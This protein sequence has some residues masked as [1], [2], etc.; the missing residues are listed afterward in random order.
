MADADEEVRAAEQ[1]ARGRSPGGEGDLLTVPEGVL[2]DLGA[3]AKAVAADLA[4][5][6]VA[7]RTGSGVLVELGGDI[8][9]RGAH[10]AGGWQILVDD[11]PGGRWAIQ[12]EGWGHMPVCEVSAILE[13]AEAIVLMDNGP[14]DA[15]D[16]RVALRQGRPVVIAEASSSVRSITPL[17][18]DLRQASWRCRRD[19]RRSRS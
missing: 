8:A 16:R 7:S 14:G 19:R 4:A 5:D 11:G 18:S 6:V 1:L 12:H 9:T 13:G 3:T 15:A 10:P 17:P 2:L